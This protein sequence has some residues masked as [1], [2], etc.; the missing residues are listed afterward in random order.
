MQYNSPIIVIPPKNDE[1]RDSSKSPEMSNTRKKRR[2]LFKQTSKKIV[3]NLDQTI[4]NSSPPPFLDKPQSDSPS[5]SKLRF[6]LKKNLD[7]SNDSFTQEESYNCCHSTLKPSAYQKNSEKRYNDDSRPNS[8]QSSASSMM[9]QSIE[10]RGTLLDHLYH[11]K[12]NINELS[13]EELI[14]V[15]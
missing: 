6:S 15:S 10:I 11:G 14:D 1:L 8:A 12:L 9:G 7:N 13:K 5:N 3:Q 2:E 4:E